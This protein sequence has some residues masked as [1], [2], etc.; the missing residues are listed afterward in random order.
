[1]RGGAWVVGCGPPF[2]CCADGGGR[3]C[4][5]FSC[6]S[7]KC[8]TAAHDARY[9]PFFYPLAL[10]R[11]VHGAVERPC[12]RC[13]LDPAAFGALSVADGGDVRVR[14][15]VLPDLVSRSGS[16]QRRLL[17]WQGLRAPVRQSHPGCPA[18]R[19]T[20]AL[21]AVAD[22]TARDCADKS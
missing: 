3:V 20:E 10:C 13:A 4:G 9:G 17:C 7:G 16:L 11:R 2:E 14:H 8:A 22:T 6:H 1:D 19:D 5:D 15:R 21:R 18:V 12:A